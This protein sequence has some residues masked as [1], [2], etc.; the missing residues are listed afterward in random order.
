MSTEMNLIIK[1]TIHLMNKECIYDYGN[2]EEGSYFGDISILLNQPNNIS[3][4]SN[5]FDPTPL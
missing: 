2:L 4:V 5:D 3:Y 1:G